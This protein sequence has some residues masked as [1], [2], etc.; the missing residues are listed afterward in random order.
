MYF[1]TS[2]KSVSV[3]GAPRMAML[4]TWSFHSVTVRRVLTMFSN[5]WHAMQTRSIVASVTFTKSSSSAGVRS[6]ML[7]VSAGGAGLPFFAGW[8][9]AAALAATAIA[10]NIAAHVTS[11]AGPNGAGDEGNLFTA[12]L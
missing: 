12:C 2:A 11:H 10:R 9:C 8:A 4:V 3:P 6:P 7:F 1:L 5:G